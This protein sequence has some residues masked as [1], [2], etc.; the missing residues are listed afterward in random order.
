[1]EIKQTTFEVEYT[2]RRGNKFTYY[3]V[4]FGNG[5]VQWQQ[6]TAIGKQMVSETLAAELE[7]E[8]ATTLVS[9]LVE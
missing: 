5:V 3:R 1:M 4:S 2:H 9:R 8:F 7:K 6:N